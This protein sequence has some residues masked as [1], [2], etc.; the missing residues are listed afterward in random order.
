M[1]MTLHALTED[2]ALK[3]IERREQGGD[4]MPLIIVGHGARASLLHRQPRLGAV[5]RLNL[6]LLIDGQHNGVVRRIDVKSH[7][8]LELG[9][10]LRVSGQLELTHQMRPKTVGTPDPLH[11]T[12]ADAGRF[13]H[14]RAGPV[15]GPRWRFGKRHGHHT[16]DHFRAQRRDA[17][18]S[19]FI[20]P[21]P[22]STL[23]SEPLLPTPD[24]RLGLAG[25]LHDLGSA[26]TI[27]R[28]KNDF[29][30]PNV[31][32]RAVA[33]RHRRLKRTAIGGAQSDV[34]SLVHSSDSHV[35]GRQGIPKRIEMSDL[36]H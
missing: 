1:A 3:D 8:V 34:R 16:F 33:V 24:H 4:A 30:P 21:K 5:Q 36:D 13:G 18:W 11:R 7:D 35:R 32:L 31:L 19:R 20:P 14:G 27:G 28:Q 6:A 29:C 17:R 22:H 25:R 2:L 9:G 12:D 23:L 10:K 26:A 15:A